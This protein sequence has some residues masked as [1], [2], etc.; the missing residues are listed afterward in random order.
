L[1]KGIDRT[2][3]SPKTYPAVGALILVDLDINSARKLFM[4]AKDLYPSHRTIRETSLTA[5]APIFTNPH[6]K[7][8]FQYRTLKMSNPVRK[9][10]A[11]NLTLS[12]MNIIYFYHPRHKWRG[13]LTG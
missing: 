6:K 11:L 12:K 9:D 1:V 2:Y 7:P 4:A 13:F 3:L 5:D 10:G 8:P